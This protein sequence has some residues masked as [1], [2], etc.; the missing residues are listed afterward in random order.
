MKP[1]IHQL[2]LIK[3]VE[4]QK[5]M[6]DAGVIA[7]NAIETAIRLT[8]PGVTEHQIFATIDYQCRMNGADYLAYP[9]VV[10]AGSNATVIHYI[11][12]NQMLRDGDLILVDAGEDYNYHVS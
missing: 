11:N 2:R 7:S 8:K 3:S 6:A 4:E 9:P 10:A 5:S 12:N 1:L